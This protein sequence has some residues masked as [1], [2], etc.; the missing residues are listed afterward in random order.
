MNNNKLILTTTRFVLLTLSFLLFI[1]LLVGC[2]EKQITLPEEIRT[3]ADTVGFAHQAW[4]MDSV[5]A[6]IQRTQQQDYIECL[7][8]GEVKDETLWKVAISP[9]DDY[10]YVGYL[11]PAALGNMRAKTVILIGVA[12]RAK[13]LGL[14]NKIIF[15]SY[16][17]WQAPYGAVRVS[18]IRDEIIAELPEEIYEIND[19]MQRMEHSTEALIPFLQY[20]RRD[21]EIVSILVPYMSFAQ[22][23]IL[24]LP[25]AQAIHKVIEKRKWQWGED[26][27]IAISTDAVHYGD[28]EW[29][30][31][32]FAFFGTDSSGYQLAIQHEYEIINNCLV[33]DIR[34]EKIEKFTRYTVQEK[35]FREYKWTWCGRYSVPFGLLTAYYLQS[36]ENTKLQGYFLGYGNS[37]DHPGIHVSDLR[38][39]TTAIANRNHWVGYVAVGYR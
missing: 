38:M 4:Q 11:Y 1:I 6:R 39:G 13:N 34:P 33:G 15:D 3:P 18:E 27:A 7:K 9:H 25:L 8:R 37:L 32:D 22:M 17:Q 5:M 12:H 2:S 30:G 21:L 29:G 36:E 20:N 19:Q 28:E 31:K 35:D 14:E 26:Y 10:T 23:K 24:A 16:K